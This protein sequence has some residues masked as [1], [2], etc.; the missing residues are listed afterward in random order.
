MV[1]I[2]EST[3]KELNRIRPDVTKKRVMGRRGLTYGDIVEFLVDFYKA[4]K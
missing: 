3:L 2:K 4:R 1:V